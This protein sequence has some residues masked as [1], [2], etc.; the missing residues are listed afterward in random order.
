MKRIFP[1][2]ENCITCK[3]CETACVV[4]HSK[5]KNVYLAWK[6]NPKVVS[7]A[8]VHEREALSYSAMCRHCDEPECVFACPNNAIHKDASG[9]VIVDTERCQGC[10]MCLMS[11]RFSSIKPFIDIEPGSRELIRFSNKCDLCPDRLSPAC[12]D[13]C[14]NGALSYE[15]RTETAR[16]AVITVTE[17]TD[18]DVVD[19]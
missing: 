6:E 8:T 1:H 2:E 13:A 5:T 10:W 18:E 9:R 7:R 19:V 14:P 12:V 15:E 17:Q 11:C 4:E 3:L 16:P